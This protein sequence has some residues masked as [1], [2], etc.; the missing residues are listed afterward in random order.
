M[1]CLLDGCLRGWLFDVCVTFRCLILLVFMIGVCDCFVMVGL[2]AVWVC[3]AWW[4]IGD[5]L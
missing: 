4:W 2:L 3:V 1:V 5:C